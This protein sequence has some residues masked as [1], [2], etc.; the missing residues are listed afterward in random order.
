MR[1]LCNGDWLKITLCS[2]KTALKVAWE[3]FLRMA[4]INFI[5]GVIFPKTALKVAWETFVKGWLKI[6]VILPKTA[7][8]VAWE[9]SIFENG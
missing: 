2:P 7:L 6:T 4:K 1:S 5:F 3:I 9:I 8:K